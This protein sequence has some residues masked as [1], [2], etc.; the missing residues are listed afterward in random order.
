MLKR[1]IQN[2]DGDEW[3]VRNEAG[4]AWEGSMDAG[5][6]SDPCHA[7]GAQQYQ[8][9]RFGGCFARDTGRVHDCSS[10]MELSSVGMEHASLKPPNMNVSRRNSIA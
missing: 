3:T 9:V 2:R 6:L 7:A 8:H 5:K 4:N 10:T 1:W